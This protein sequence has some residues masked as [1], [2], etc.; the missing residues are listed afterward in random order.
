MEYIVR[1]NV[2]TDNILKVAPK[3]KVFKGGFVAIL[4]EYTFQNAWQDKKNIKRFKSVNSLT[5][6]LSKNYTEEET[7]FLDFNNSC[8]E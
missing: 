6:Y 3:G 8:L 2:L 1:E 7:D 4:E 5:K